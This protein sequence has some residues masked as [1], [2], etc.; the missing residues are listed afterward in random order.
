[1]TGF[2]CNT[3]CQGADEVPDDN[4]F[5]CKKTITA[6][7]FPCPPTTY[8]RVTGQS[9]G[10]NC[11]S[12]GPANYADVYSMDSPGTCLAGHKCVNSSASRAPVARY[13][14]GDTDGTTSAIDYEKYT[15]PVDYSSNGCRTSA[16][17]GP[18]APTM[19]AE[20]YTTINTENSLNT[21]SPYNRYMCKSHGDVCAKGTYCQAESYEETACDAGRYCPDAY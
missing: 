9:S 13:G 4:D 14:I 8:N 3:V 2:T 15:D 10:E 18:W 16:E 11:I 17:S 6:M 19:S 12:A 20:D 1:M 5:I 21:L 7:E